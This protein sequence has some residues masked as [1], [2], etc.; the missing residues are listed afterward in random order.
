MQS[1]SQVLMIKPVRFGYNAETAVNNYFQQ[2]VDH[3]V[4]EK[5]LEEFDALVLKLRSHKIIVN[6]VED[7]I[8]PH[9]PDSIFPNNWISFHEDNS[10]TLYPMFAENRRKERKETVLQFIRD[11]F[12]H[13][14]DQ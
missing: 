9:T 13:Y 12:Q 3:S 11:S 5:A 2:T 8:D 6:V 10:I 1:T 14:T 7:S 4:Q